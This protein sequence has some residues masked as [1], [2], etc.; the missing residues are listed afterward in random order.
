MKERNEG[1]R[2]RQVKQVIVFEGNKRK[3]QKSKINRNDNE[4]GV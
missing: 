2:E 1:E 3:R 4:K